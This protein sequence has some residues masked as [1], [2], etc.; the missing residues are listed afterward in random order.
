MSVTASREYA[1]CTVET[2]TIAAAT[3]PAVALPYERRASHHVAAI[4]PSPSTSTTT[5]AVSNDGWLCHAWNG[6]STY[7]SSV[8]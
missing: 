2:A 3:A 8:G 7:M 6:A 5:R 4:E 1:T